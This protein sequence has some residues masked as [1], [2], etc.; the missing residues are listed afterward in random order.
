MDHL[1]S[2]INYQEHKWLICGDLMVVGLFLGLQGGYTEYP[3]FQCLWDIQAHDQ[4]YVRQDWLL[5]QG[6][7]PGLHNVQSHPLIELNKIQL[8]LLLI[9]LK[10]MKNIVKVID[11]EDSR[12]AFLQEKFPRISMEKFKAGI[13]NDPQIRELM[14]DPMFDEAWSKAELSTWQSLK[15]V[16]TKFLGNHW[17]VEYNKEIEKF[18]PTRG[19]NVSQTALSVVT[20]FSKELWRF[21]WR[22][23]L[24]PL[25]R[26]LHH[27]RTLPSLVE[28]KLFHWLLLVLETDVVAALNLALFV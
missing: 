23:S 24:V 18:P 17:S 21:K 4:H 7:K 2:A 15:S 9:K 3:C 5:R 19:T 27:G 16:I 1:L 26:H 22:A 6:L 11:R 10:V 13:F 12:F 8:L 20:L 14:K 25:P 28:Y